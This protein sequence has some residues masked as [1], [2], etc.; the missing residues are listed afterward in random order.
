MKK[1]ITLAL[2]LLPFAFCIADTP[3]LTL[4]AN[5][6]LFRGALDLNNAGDALKNNLCTVAEFQA[7]LQAQADELTE[8]KNDL[9]KLRQRI[10]ATLQAKL[11]AELKTGEGPKVALLRTL[12]AEANKSDDD[13]KRES[14]E[15][16]IAAKQAE[17][18]K[19]KD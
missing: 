8:A 18:A 4:A 5:G 7:A 13:L 15:A 3:A 6:H 12:Q 10:A 17:L 9:A 11:E 2:C 16:E 19:L 14:L 1:L